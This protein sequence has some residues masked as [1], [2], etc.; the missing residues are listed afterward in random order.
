MAYAPLAATMRPLCP[1]WLIG[2]RADIRRR[3]RV[4]M[5]VPG[6]DAASLNALLVRVGGARDRAAFEMLFRHFAPRIKAYLLRL[7]AASPVAEE[8]AQE[9]M[10]SVWRK[11]ALFDPAKASAGTWIFTI[12]RNLRI[13][14]LR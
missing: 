2:G 11:A 12:A 4:R 9:A 14:A 8:L 3:T 10:L 1:S 13:D 5:I 7:G 6:Q